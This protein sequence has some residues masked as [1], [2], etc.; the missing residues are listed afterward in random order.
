MLNRFKL[1]WRIRVKNAEV[2]VIAGK[3]ST[4]FVNAVKD[5]ARLHGIERG[6]I[7]CKGVGKH[8]RLKFSKDFPE[9]GRQAI[10]NSW[11]P[12]TA[13]GPGGGARRNG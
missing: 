5:I 7:D 1:G 6:E 10:R 9:K 12:P 11:T 13:P 4:H 2:D 3:P 8:A